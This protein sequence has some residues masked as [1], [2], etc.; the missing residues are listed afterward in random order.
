MWNSTEKYIILIESYNS[1]DIYE[2]AHTGVVKKRNVAWAAQ[3]ID[4]L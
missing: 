3:L 4:I 2:A 1:Y